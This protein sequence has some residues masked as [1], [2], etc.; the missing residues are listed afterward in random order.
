MPVALAAAAWRIQAVGAASHRTRPARPRN[1]VHGPGHGP[2]RVPARILDRALDLARIRDL[3]PGPAQG[4]ARIRPGHRPD[5]ARIPIRPRLRRR[6][7]TTR[8]G[9]P[10]RSPPASRSPRR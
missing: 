8:S 10:P 4:Q 3:D 7:G 6:T 5:L 1:R 9:M 2:N